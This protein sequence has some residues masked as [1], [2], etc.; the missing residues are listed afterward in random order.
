MPQ[1]RSARA[2]LSSLLLAALIDVTR[3]GTELHGRP[4]RVYSVLTHPIDGQP[5]IAY[6]RGEALSTAVAD[7]RDFPRK[8]ASISTQAQEPESPQ[9]PASGESWQTPDEPCKRLTNRGKRLTNRGKRP[10]NPGQRRK[11]RRCLRTQTAIPRSRRLT[12][13][14]TPSQTRETRA[15][16]DRGDG[17][18]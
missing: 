3:P 11:L 2:R 12:S 10:T 14:A 17:R 15:M 5:W 13:P 7:R 6:G 18:L 8:G 1:R 4:V 16:L 9:E